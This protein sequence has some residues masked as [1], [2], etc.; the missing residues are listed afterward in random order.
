MSPCHLSSVPEMSSSRP[1]DATKPVYVVTE[2]LGWP[3]KQ[4][5]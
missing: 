4:P 3:A 1:E 5:E 2:P